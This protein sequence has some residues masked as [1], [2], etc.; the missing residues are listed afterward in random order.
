MFLFIN[1]DRPFSQFKKIEMNKKNKRDLVREEKQQIIKGVAL[2]LFAE[3]GYEATSVNAIAKKAAISK[4]L[5][6]HYFSS[7]EE[8]LKVIWNDI[9][10]RFNPTKFNE[11]KTMITDAEAEEFMDKL[12]ELCKNNRPQWRLYYQLFFQP[13]VIEYFTSTYIKDNPVQK[14]QNKFLEYFGE[15]IGGPNLS[16]GMFTVLVFIKGFSMVTPYTEE[17]FS[18]E[19]LDQ[20]KEYLKTIFFKNR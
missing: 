8:L 18:N 3:K 4:G 7:K 6:Y 9:L 13:K 20:Y 1:F 14:T 17:V 10:E 11:D 2:E 5:L 19:F 16:M 15:K 12:F